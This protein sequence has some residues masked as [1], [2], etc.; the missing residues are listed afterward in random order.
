M[1]PLQ[2]RDCDHDRVNDRVHDCDHDD[3]CVHDND[4]A[5][6]HDQHFTLE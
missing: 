6:D 2:H 3:D 4:R 1:L 5:H